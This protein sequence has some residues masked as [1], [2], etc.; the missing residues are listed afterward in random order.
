M[1]II[2]LKPT[3]SFQSDFPSSLYLSDYHGETVVQISE[4]RIAIVDNNINLG[5]H[6]EVF[7]L[8]FDETNKSFKVLGRYNYINELFND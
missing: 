4:N 8:E 6:G 3:P 5:M 2:A 1:V 7:L